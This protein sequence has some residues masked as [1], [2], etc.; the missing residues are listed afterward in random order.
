[1]TRLLSIFLNQFPLY[2]STRG[3]YHDVT[4]QIFRTCLNATLKSF[5]PSGNHLLERHR[6]IMQ[7]H[8]KILDFSQHLPLG[9]QLPWNPPFPS[10]PSSRKKNLPGSSSM[11]WPCSR[12]TTGYFTMVSNS[13]SFRIQHP[14]VL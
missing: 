2:K 1:M 10:C 4:S 9:C 7:H 3:T 8:C 6:F 12:K 5:L 13:F 11:M 14:L